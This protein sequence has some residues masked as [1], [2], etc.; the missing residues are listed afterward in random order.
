MVRRPEI[1]QSMLHGPAILFMD[2]PTVGLDPAAPATV[3]SHVLD[4]KK[5]LGMTLVITSHYMEEVE[6][7]CDRLALMANGRIVAA[8]SVMELKQKAGNDASLDDAFVR[9]TG[10]V[11][12]ER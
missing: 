5:F 8:G 2:E 7:L 6:K 10:A 9:L 3:W 12:E 11:S 4:L 1:A